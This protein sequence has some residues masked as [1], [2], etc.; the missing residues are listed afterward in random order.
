[1]C[2]RPFTL[3][4]TDVQLGDLHQRLRNTRLP[5]SLKPS[6]WEDGVSAGFMKH[7]LD[8]WCTHFDWRAQEQR[9]N[10]LPQFLTEVAGQTIHFVHQRGVGPRPMPLVITHGWPGSFLEMEGLLP[11][12]TDPAAHGGD[13]ADAFDV[14][15]PSLPGYGSSPAPTTEGTGA[16]EIASLWQRLMGQLGYERFGAQGGDIGAGVS[17]WLARDHGA[18]V[19]GAHLNYIPGSFRPGLRDGEATWSA[20]EQDFLDRS[21]RFAAT[22]GAYAA[23]HSTKPQTLA[24]ALADSPLGLAAWMMEKFH[25]WIDHPDDLEQVVSLDTLLT[26]I[27][28]YWFSGNIQASLRLYKENRQNPLVFQP[29]ERVTPPL[30]VTLFP[31][32]LPMPPHSWVAR[33]FDITHWEHAPKGGHFAA[34]EQPRILAEQIR[35]FFTP[36]RQ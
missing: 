12:L 23:L 13:P 31:K 21:S 36:L 9:I 6:S 8:Y 4:V 30:G 3:A 32:E 35:T 22:E 25:A 7:L 28:L 2:I 17:M 29:T 5:D 16:R 11:L 15:V 33:V 18:Q 26:D 20:Q 1:M 14:V 34:M 24:F 27:S 19:L 10:R